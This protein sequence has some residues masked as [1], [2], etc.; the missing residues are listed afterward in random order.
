MTK[1]SSAVTTTVGLLIIK[2]IVEDITNRVVAEQALQESEEKFFRAFHSSP[3]AI[4]ISRLTDGSILDV[5][6]GF[7]SVFGYRRDE[8]IGR[9]TH[10]FS[11]WA[12]PL[13]RTHYIQMI[14]ESGRVRDY[15]Y[16][17]RVKSGALREGLLSGEMV[18][19]GSEKYLLGTIRDITKRK[20][21]EEDLRRSA[22]FTSALLNAIPTPVFYKGRDG[23]YQGCNRAF[24]KFMGVTADDIQGKTVHE[25]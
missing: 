8:V 18:R 19:I 15:E 22:N 9:T 13:D 1:P 4:V 11:L 23:R 24:S 10:D 5:N 17:F 12:D 7:T 2:G 20:W 3:D 14:T 21:A 25:L 16:R 6:E